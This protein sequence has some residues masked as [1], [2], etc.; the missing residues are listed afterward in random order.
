MMS[1]DVYVY[2]GV[3]RNEVFWRNYTSN[4]GGM[5]GKAS[6]G[7]WYDENI[8]PRYKDFPCPV[9]KAVAKLI[10]R[11]MRSDPGTYEAMNPKNGWGDY[12]G[13]LKF[14]RAIYRA[15]HRN[16]DGVFYISS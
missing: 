16:P 8:V 6:V 11:S 12:D 13:A 9:M 14:M 10:I 7:I 4:V 3:N 1:Y 15:C 2:V 5:F